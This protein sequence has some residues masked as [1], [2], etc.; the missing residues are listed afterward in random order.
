VR[1]TH[2]TWSRGMAPSG[3]AWPGEVAGQGW[4]GASCSR[5]AQHATRLSTWAGGLTALG[6]AGTGMR[7]RR[8]GAGC[9]RPRSARGPTRT[10]R[11]RPRSC[12]A[13]CAAGA[14]RV[15]RH[16]GILRVGWHARS[17][18]TWLARP[19]PG[20]GRRRRAAPARPALGRAEGARAHALR[21][22]LRQRENR[23]RGRM[24]TYPY[25]L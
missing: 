9:G 5:P 3:T 21:V 22:R 6:G 23:H 25:E 24:C 12:A 20:L 18:D 14:A 13:R 7:R 16:A 15:G 4:S 8:R 10:P 1:G 2:C 17:S 19:W 11:P